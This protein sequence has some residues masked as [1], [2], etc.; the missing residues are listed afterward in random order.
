MARP[1]V[2]ESDSLG[3]GVDK[4]LTQIRSMVL[5][6]ELLPGEKVQQAALA[7]ALGISRIPVREALSKL[8]SEG[9]LDHKANTGYTVARFNSED[10]SEIYLMRRLLE[11]EVLK[12]AN[13]ALVNMKLLTETHKGMI[14]AAKAGDVEKFQRQNHEF[15]F[16]IFVASPLK[17]V[18]QE[19]E[20][21]WYMSGFYRAVYLYE[22]ET[23]SRLIREHQ[24]IIEAVKARDLKDL[25]KKTDAHRARSEDFV[26][27]R[28]GRSRTSRERLSKG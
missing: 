4:C 20:R 17:V 6:G 5:S 26:V 11:T 18:V 9:V 1:A 27:Q 16:A 14:A 3:S 7:E 24:G 2:I 10:L 19:L 25:I 23:T 13:L 22:P 15:H 12:S 8:H 28:L 21:L